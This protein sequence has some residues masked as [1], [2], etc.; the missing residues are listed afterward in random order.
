[1]KTMAKNVY[2]ISPTF[3]RTMSNASDNLSDKYLQSSIREAQEMGLQSILGTSLYNSILDKV[4][5]SEIGNIE[6]I[7]YKELLDVA[8]FY[9]LYEVLKNVILITSVKL[10]NFG[11]NQ[12]NDDNLRVLSITE[13]MKLKDQYQVKVDFYK[14]RLQEYVW[15]NR[16]SFAELDECTCR[17]LHSNLYSSASSSIWLGGRRGRVL[18]P[19]TNW[20]KKY[21]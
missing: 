1:M 11:A 18:T 16:E 19:L 21:R 2:L 10:N 14:R 8:Q 7:A 9:L 12:T 13:L 17:S 5:A 6:N 15:N 20:I 4:E 3:V